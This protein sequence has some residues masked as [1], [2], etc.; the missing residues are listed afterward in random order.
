MKKLLLKNFIQFQ[1]ITCSEVTITVSPYQGIGVIEPV[2]FPL[3]L[4]S[5]GCLITCCW[6]GSADMEQKWEQILGHTPLMSQFLSTV[7]THWCDIKNNI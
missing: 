7:L 2:F 4:I 3:I 5:F 6:W 1:K